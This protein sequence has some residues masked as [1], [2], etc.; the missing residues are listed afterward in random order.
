M[1][2]KRLPKFNP[3]ILASLLMNLAWKLGWRGMEPPQD[4]EEVTVH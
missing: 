1:P 3:Y 2:S 4:G